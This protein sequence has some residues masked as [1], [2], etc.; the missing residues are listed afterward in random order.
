MI[1]QQLDRMVQIG[2]TKIPAINIQVN[3]F[4]KNIGQS[5]DGTT[6]LVLPIYFEIMFDGGFLWIVESY[7]EDEIFVEQMMVV[8][9]SD[10]QIYPG[11]ETYDFGCFSSWENFLDMYLNYERK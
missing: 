5:N 10:G 2:D 8:P 6:S 7:S 4:P 3:G 9:E 1:P 11:F